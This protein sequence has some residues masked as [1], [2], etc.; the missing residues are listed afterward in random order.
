[1][2]DPIPAAL[3]AQE[4]MQRIYDS[5][6]PVVEQNLKGH[7][8]I[9][10]DPLEV[11]EQLGQSPGSFRAILNWAGEA[12]TGHKDSGIVIHSI[13]ITVSHNRGLSIIRGSN[14]FLGRGDNPALVV[15]SDQV[16]RLMRRLRFPN[17][18]TSV[19]LEYGGTDPVGVDGSMIDAF[20]QTWRLTA[21]VPS[22]IEVVG[23][24]AGE[25]L[26]FGAGIALQP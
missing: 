1:M 26:D 16:R 23:T 3:S 19:T 4:I 12:P 9:A 20:T 11:I 10:R 2:S 5:L 18:V 14:L 7:L 17:Q 21:A 24:P 25:A 6:K 22:D 15:L 13:Q 8:S